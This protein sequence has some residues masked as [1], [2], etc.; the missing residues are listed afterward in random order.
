MKLY[1]SKGACSMI[2]RIILNELHINADYESVDLKTKVTETNKNFLEINPKGAVATL[3]LD[4]GEILTENAVIVQ[5]LADIKEAHELLPKT[6]DFNRYRVLEWLNYMTTEVHKSFA[7]LFNA[8]VSQN[9]K[10]EIFIPLIKHKLKFVDKHLHGKEFLVLDRF[11]LPDAYLYVMLL[12]TNHFKIDLREY[13]ALS[14][15]FNKLS[16]RDSIIKS[17]QEEK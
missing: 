11:T 16:R 3:A 6:G 17:L 9:L 7:I 15:Y 5:Y 14:A 8:D 1:Y 12:W 4:D 10:D 2:T 13:P